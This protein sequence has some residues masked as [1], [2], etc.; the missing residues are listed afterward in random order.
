MLQSIGSQRV[1]DDLATEQQQKKQIEYFLC[2]RCCFKFFTYINSLF[3]TYKIGTITTPAWQMR[4]MT[5]RKLRP[6]KAI[7]TGCM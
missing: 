7:V 6:G 2:I 1:R 5:K 4:K 3:L